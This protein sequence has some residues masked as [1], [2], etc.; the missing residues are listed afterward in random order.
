MREI[1]VRS[2]KP[3]DFNGDEEKFQRDLAL[4]NNTTIIHF[5][6]TLRSEYTKAILARYHGIGL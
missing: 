3:L 2:R 1:M 4:Q 5:Q 6:N